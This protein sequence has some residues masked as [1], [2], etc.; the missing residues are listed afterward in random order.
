MRLLFFELESL[1]QRK[2][3]SID[4]N[5]HNS[6]ANQFIELIRK[7]ALLFAGNR[8]KYVDAS[9]RF[10]I[11]NLIHDLR[12][13]LRG[14]RSFTIRTKGVSYTTPEKSHEIINFRESSGG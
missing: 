11:E 4:S 5:T 9:V 13:G 14:E 3:F 2:I 1:F 8:S 7:F 6:H 10:E 12:R